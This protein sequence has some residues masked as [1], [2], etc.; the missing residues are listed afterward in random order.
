LELS[1]VG[2]GMVESLEESSFS[3]PHG[4]TSCKLEPG[5]QDF[6]GIIALGTSIDWQKT[7]KPEGQNKDKQRG[8]LATMIFEGI[9]SLSNT[10]IL[11]TKPSTTTSFYS[12]DVD[13]HRLATFLSQQNIMTRSGYFC[14]HYYLQNIK[15]YPPLLRISLGLH[16]TEKDVQK[17]LEVLR[18]I[19]SNVR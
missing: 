16:N 5:L 6:A 12:E 7:Y 19:I 2:G 8:Q 9:S 17:F 15:K 1:F 11:S 18:K 4:D 3:T 10:H 13:A 14:C